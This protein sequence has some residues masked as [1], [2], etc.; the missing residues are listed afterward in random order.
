MTAVK[1]DNEARVR[2]DA[3]YINQDL[4]LS[5]TGC[6]VDLC[7]SPSSIP[8]L[9]ALG[10]HKLLVLPIFWLIRTKAFKMKFLTLASLFALTAATPTPTQPESG[11]ARLAKRATISDAAN[12]GYATLNGG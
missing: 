10:S 6:S 12:L 1:L 2:E 3:I 5:F 8:W 11:T 9:Q 7:P 4:T